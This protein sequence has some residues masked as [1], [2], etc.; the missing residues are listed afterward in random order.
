[1]VCP[2]L[3]LLA[4]ALLVASSVVPLE[5]E[6]DSPTPV[7][8]EP[9]HPLHLAKR[10]AAGRKTRHLRP[11]YENTKRD[12]TPPDVGQV[13]TFPATGIPQPTRGIYGGIRTGGTNEEIDRQNPDYVTPPL[14]DNG[15]I[16]NL[17]WSFSLSHTRL[18]NG[19][20]I[21]EQTIT[22]LPPSKDVSAAELRIAPN[23]Y[24]ELHWHRVGEWGI[25][26][27][28][29]GRITALD[30][31]GRTYISDIKGPQNGTDPDTFT[32]PANFPHGIQALDDGLDLLLIFSDG[33][34]DATG[35]TFMLSDWLVHTPIE[36]VAQNLGLS[37]SDLKKLPSPDPYIFKST[38]PPPQEGHADEQAKESPN[39]NVPNPYVFS[40]SQQEKVEAPGGW[41]KIQD[42]TRNFEASWA[43]TAYVYVEPNGLRELHWH[44]QDEWLYIISGHGRATAFAAGSAART[45]DLQTGDTAVFPIAYGHYIKNLSPTEPLIFIEVFKAEK[46]VDFSA[47]QWLAL[48]PSQT[49]A[50]LLNITVAQADGLIK[51]KQILIA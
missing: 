28:G 9:E 29:S 47:T 15:I 17:K 36:I 16:P 2:S 50:D 5:R 4:S 32:F 3:V 1:M 13:A 38:V 19:G 6:L 41:V 40:L 25:V 37:I 7:A 46:Y 21:R 18:L 51:T 11:F 26:L 42:S 24:R 14:T 22:D 39:G 20:W 33:D 10:D 27:G 30:D 31:E 34:F 23:A 43:A 44:S 49:V 12:I 35:T 8:R 48:T 45:F